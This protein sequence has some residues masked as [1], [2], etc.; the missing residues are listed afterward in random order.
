M[1]E[2]RTTNTIEGVR[3]RTTKSHPNC[4]VCNRLSV[5]AHESNRVANEEETI[6]KAIEV[7]EAIKIRNALPY[8]EATTQAI[9][10]IEQFNPKNGILQTWKEIEQLINTPLRR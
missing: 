7:N 3:H 8:D 4:P 2:E 6:S 9:Q 10:E 5:A 1:N